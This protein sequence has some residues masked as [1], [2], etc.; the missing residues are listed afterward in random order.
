MKFLIFTMADVAKAAEA[1]Q[2]ADKARASLPAGLKTEAVYTCLGVP[3]PGFP[4]NKGLIISVIE[5]ESVEAM[6]AL[7]YPIV[8]TGASVSCVPVLEMAIG[9]AAEQEKKLRG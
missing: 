3:F 6:A 8:L 9:A 2:A 5:V 7:S 1:A 4:E